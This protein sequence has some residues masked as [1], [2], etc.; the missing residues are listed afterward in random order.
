MSLNSSIGDIQME[1]RKVF[2]F[3]VLAIIAVAAGFSLAGKANADQTRIMIP[4]APD[5]IIPGGQATEGLS[6]IPNNNENIRIEYRQ[7]LFD[8][9]KEDK[10]KEQDT[11]SLNKD[12]DE[13]SPKT[14]D[15]DRQDINKGD[16]G[17][18]AP[19]RD[20]TEDMGAGG[21]RNRTNSENPQYVLQFRTDFS[22]NIGNR[23]DQTDRDMDSY[24][25]EN[26]GAE[27][28]MGTPDKDSSDDAAALPPGTTGSS[29]KGILNIDQV[30]GQ[31]YI[32]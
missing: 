27:S 26:P 17:A 11:G 29:D 1:L 14:M 25:Q 32:T 4:K 16:S 3:L 13:S 5:I 23:Q 20:Q 18:Y 19:D 7:T 12:Y 30:K 21:S 15:R 9:F 28:D 24:G 31:R 10:D 2:K 22:G 8:W 6:I